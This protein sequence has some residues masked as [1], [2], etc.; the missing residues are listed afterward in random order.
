MGSGGIEGITAVLKWK[1]GCI[2]GSHHFVWWPLYPSARQQQ[3]HNKDDMKQKKKNKSFG[4]SC[5]GHFLRAALY[6]IQCISVYFLSTIIIIIY[7]QDEREQKPEEILTGGNL[8]LFID[9]SLMMKIIMNIFLTAA[10]IFWTL[11]TDLDPTCA[12]FGGFHLKYT[13]FNKYIDC[14][15]KYFVEM[16]IWRIP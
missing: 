5:N 6:S 2:L 16:N 13:Q 12:L 1:T 4:N 7:T 10:I 11:R 3:Q 8:N 15:D 14:V 9:R